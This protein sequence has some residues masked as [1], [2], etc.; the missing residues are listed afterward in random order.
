MSLNQ[1]APYAPDKLTAD[2]LKKLETDLAAI[3]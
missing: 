3:Q 2:V 1:V